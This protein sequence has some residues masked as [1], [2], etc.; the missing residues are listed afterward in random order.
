MR[1]SNE[2]QLEFDSIK[3]KYL[4]FSLYTLAIDKADIMEVNDLKALATKTDLRVL[5]NDMREILVSYFNN[6]RTVR[7]T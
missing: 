6:L 5:Y 3:S 7:P 2:I 4:L 1:V